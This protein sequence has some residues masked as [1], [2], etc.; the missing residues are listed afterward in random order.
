MSNRQLLNEAIANTGTSQWLPIL[1]VRR[2]IT[3][4]RANSIGAGIPYIDLSRSS[5][6]IEIVRYYEKAIAVE[7][8]ER[9]RLL[10]E[11]AELRKQN[12][13]LTRQRDESERKVTVEADYASALADR[14]DVAEWI[15]TQLRK[16]AS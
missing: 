12:Q 15:I 6:R 5:T 16:A 4:D 11:I 14:L 8:I 7:E 2:R 3:H 9:N 13:K 10:D 1:S